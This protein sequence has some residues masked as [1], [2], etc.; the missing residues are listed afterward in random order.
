M[1]TE[2]AL[3][4]NSKPAFRH[5]PVERMLSVGRTETER[6]FRMISDQTPSL[7]WVSDALWRARLH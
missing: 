6:R 1:A 4:V 5:P 3:S 2:P 7:I